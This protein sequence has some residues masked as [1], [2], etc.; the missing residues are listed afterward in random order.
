MRWNERN[1]GVCRRSH[2]HLR[3]SQ[4]LRD[5]RDEAMSWMSLDNPLMIFVNF[6]FTSI[7]RILIVSLRDGF[8]LGFTILIQAPRQWKSAAWQPESSGGVVSGGSF[9]A[10]EDVAYGQVVHSTAGG[11]DLREFFLDEFGMLKPEM[12]QI[13]PS[14]LRERQSGRGQIR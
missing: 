9:S 11:G 3:E 14:I 12:W 1:S 6:H 10:R 4:M 7:S 13:M 2:R 5:P 8:F